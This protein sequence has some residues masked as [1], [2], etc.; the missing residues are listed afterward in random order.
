MDCLAAW[1]FT[2][3]N[4]IV[5]AWHN[6]KK[7]FEVKVNLG[8]RNAL[9][10]PEIMQDLKDV[11]H[12]V[13]LESRF[14]L[15]PYT[16]EKAISKRLLYLF[17]TELL[18][19]TSHQVMSS[20]CKRDDE[21]KK[22]VSWTAKA[23]GW[24]IIAILNLGM[25]F[26][27]FLFA[28]SQ[29]V[30]NQNAWLRSF[31]VWF[32]SEV[33]IVSTLIV[34]ITHIVIP[35]MIMGDIHKVKTEILTM[36]VDLRSTARQTLMSS[37]KN[38]ND[39]TKSDLQHGFDASSLLLVS[40]RLAK[41]LPQN[42]VSKV[43]LRFR[44]PYPPR[45]FLKKKSVDKIYSKKFS[46]LATSLSIVIMFLLQHISAMDS[47][48]QDLLV[49]EVSSL[50]TIYVLSIFLDL[51]NIHPALV[52]LPILVSML[53]IHFFIEFFKREHAEAAAKLKKM[54]TT[55]P[56]AAVTGDMSALAN[57]TSQSGENMGAIWGE[58]G[59]EFSSDEDEDE[60]EGE[61]LN[62]DEN[63]G[64][65]NGG[66]DD[67]DVDD[68]E[69]SEQG[70]IEVD[71]FLLVPV[72][73]ELPNISSEESLDLFVPEEGL[74]SKDTLVFQSDWDVA[75]ERIPSDLLPSPFD[76]LP[77]VVDVIESEDDADLKGLPM[78]N[79][80]GAYRSLEISIKEDDDSS[81]KSDD[82]PQFFFQPPQVMESFDDQDFRAEI[83]IDGEIP[84]PPLP[85]SAWGLDQ[86]GREEEDDDSSL[87]FADV[88]ASG[89]AMYMH[90]DEMVIDDFEN[91]SQSSW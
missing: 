59:M 32:F 34:V 25:L 65:G 53:V 23:I 51:Y 54:G 27:V 10:T 81:H 47:S 38:N 78:F 49:S 66:N 72:H 70:S 13:E 80:T 4:K 40:H 26:Y 63:A 82:L 62:G 31:I 86:A 44:S 15:S 30:G 58:L 88:K 76:I 33:F 1:G 5:K 24:A 8:P 21:T 74:V 36:L 56:L 37:L 3:P 67:N 9:I 84:L 57:I 85:V 41:L 69:N 45:M 83:N 29:S 68:G 46:F 73:I 60:R 87:E 55:K 91:N 71:E 77:A 52:A 6:F 22:S 75:D 16:S 11:H 7:Y 35:S 18:P 12:K 28:S 48:I 61:R 89:M 42:P 64:G 14:M 43:I 2:H 50:F 20:K 39:N 90:S 19:A 79:E 17:S